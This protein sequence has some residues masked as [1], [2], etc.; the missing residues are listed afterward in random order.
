MMIDDDDLP[1]DPSPP[2][3]SPLRPLLPLPLFIHFLAFE[4]L[5]GVF[6]PVAFLLL[7]NRFAHAAGP[8]SLTAVLID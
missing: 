7:F 8:G 1:P 6:A 5:F 2:H 3:L 4:K